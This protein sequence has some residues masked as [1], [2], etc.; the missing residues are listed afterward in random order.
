MQ[1]HVLLLYIFILDKISCDDC[2]KDAFSAH[3]DRAKEKLD[4]F[5][6]YMV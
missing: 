1:K 5:K 6:T 3:S 2:F 4:E